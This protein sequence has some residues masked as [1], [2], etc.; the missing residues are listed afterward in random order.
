MS[1]ICIKFVFQIVKC[2]PHREKFH[3]NIAQLTKTTFN[4]MIS[5]TVSRSAFFTY[6]R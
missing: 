5:L 4:F 6:A 1:I 3:V 2:S